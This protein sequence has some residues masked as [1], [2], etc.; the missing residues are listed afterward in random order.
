[1]MKQVPTHKHGHIGNIG[2]GMRVLANCPG[3]APQQFCLALQEAS[4]LVRVFESC[5]GYLPIIWVIREIWENPRLGNTY[6]YDR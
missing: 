3:K 2:F 6:F 4:L 1:M 5:L